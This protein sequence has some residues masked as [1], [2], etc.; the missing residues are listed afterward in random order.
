MVP[1][2]CGRGLKFFSHP[3]G[4]NSK[5]TLYTCSHIFSA[6]YP[7]HR[8]EFRFKWNTSL[9]YLSLKFVACK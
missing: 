3:R 8:E 5:T 6:Q 4:T 2:F 7:K 1:F 9:T